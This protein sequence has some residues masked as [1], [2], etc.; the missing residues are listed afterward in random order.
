M[1]Q[2]VQIIAEEPRR[3]IATWDRLIGSLSVMR[4]DDVD[5][6]GPEYQPILRALGDLCHKVSMTTRSYVEHMQGGWITWEVYKV[7]EVC[8]GDSKQHGH[9]V[10]RVAM[11]A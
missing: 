11:P 8:P 5:E 3:L 6:G 4:S 10:A 1:D 2:H 9:C 7:W